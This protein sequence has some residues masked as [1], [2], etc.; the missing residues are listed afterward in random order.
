MSDVRVEAIGQIGLTVKDLAAAKAF[1][2]DVLG[3]TF[4]F[5]AGTM[6]FYQC[7]GVR[8]MLG[9]AEPGRET[10]MGGTILYF[11]VAGIE[12]VCESLRGKGVEFAQEAHV[13]AK[14][15]DHV[16]WMAFVKDADGNPVGLMEEVR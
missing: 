2:G 16:L 14:M 12:A 9:L 7:G 15:P 3:L 6:A 13:V 8:V 11:K 5:D 10:P 1:Y 4:L